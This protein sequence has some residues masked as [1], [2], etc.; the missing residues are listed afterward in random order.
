MDAATVNR[1]ANYLPGRLANSNNHDDLRRELLSE[2]ISGGHVSFAFMLHGVENSFTWDILIDHP[3]FVIGGLGSGGYPL[4]QQQSSGMSHALSTAARSVLA[5]Y[6]A[7]EVHF[8]NWTSFAQDT[9][10]VLQVENQEEP[11][12]LLLGG[13]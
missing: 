1:I 10:T 5:N 13:F 7:I 3:F 12:S 2:G 6:L 4:I 9:Q 8:A 11:P